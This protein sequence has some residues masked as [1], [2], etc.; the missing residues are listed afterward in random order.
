MTENAF[1]MGVDCAKTGG[2]RDDCP[3]PPGNPIYVKWQNG[4]AAGA[5]DS[6]KQEGAAEDPVAVKEA[7]NQGMAAAKGPEDAEVE[8]PYPQGSFLFRSWL[9]GFKENG[10][11]HEEM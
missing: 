10:G 11:K 1:G 4:F 9:R 3:F 7:Y 6:A 2:S 5:A 8:C